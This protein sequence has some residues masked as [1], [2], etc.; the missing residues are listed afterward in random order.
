[1]SETL[2]SGSDLT[3]ISYGTPIYSIETALAMLENPPQGL[4][5]VIPE[6]LRGSKIELLDL[7]SILPWDQEAIVE[8]VS[9]TRRCIVVHEAGRI[10]GLGA[11]LAA[12]IQER[13]FLRLEAPVRRVTGWE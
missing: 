13:C 1:M 9:R 7:R 10:G 2:Q 4:G 5:S 6:R 11:D 3:I 8:S 12:E